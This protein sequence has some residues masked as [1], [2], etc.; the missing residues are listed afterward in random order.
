MTDNQHG[1]TNDITL[2]DHARRRMRVIGAVAIAFVI[3]GLVYSFVRPAEYESTATLVIQAPGSVGLFAPGDVDFRPDRYAA[4]Q[5]AIMRSRSVTE[6]ALTILETDF[7]D[8]PRV[9]D[10]RRAL[11]IVSEPNSNVVEVIH[12]G[13]SPDLAQAGANALVAAYLESVREQSAALIA[14]TLATI[15]GAILELNVTLDDLESRIAQ[16]SSASS[17]IVDLENRYQL[18]LTRLAQLQEA[19]IGADEA[20]LVVI[21]TEEAD[22]GAFLE[23]VRVVRS[24]EADSSLDTAL[25]AEHDSLLDRLG[26]LTGQRYGLVLD[27]QVAGRSAVVFSAAGPGEETRGGL[28]STVA[29]SLLLG[30]LF[31]LG[32]TFVM[33]A[34]RPV[35]SNPE[36]T[37]ELLRTEVLA[38]I[39]DLSPHDS[40]L[41]SLSAPDSDGGLAFRKAATTLENRVEMVRRGLDDPIGPGALPDRDRSGRFIKATRKNQV[42]GDGR[43]VVVLSPNPGQG[44]TVVTANL[45]VATARQSQRVLAI[46]ADFEH[47]HLTEM[48]TGRSF[49][50]AGLIDVVEMG[51]SLSEAVV[52]VDVGEDSRLGLLGRGTFRLPPLDFFRMPKT[53]TFLQ[54]LAEQYDLI[55]IDTP[56]VYFA[57]YAATLAKYADEVALVIPHGS[58]VEDVREFGRRLRILPANLLGVVYNRMPTSPVARH[59][60]E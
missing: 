33:P 55:F 6:Q 27:A 3:L 49:V 26:E 42:A 9:D 46:D 2:L 39:P 50:R 41:I 60:R 53:R 11:E 19:R 4:D 23:T 18:A 17:Q 40:K 56:P 20:S 36:E 31:G 44:R 25:L 48:L 47:S 30:V 21:R 54:E 59:S 14:N 28:A 10:Y 7:D 13:P 38:D 52:E 35:V 24:L 32:L 8:L 1:V 22:I 37:A 15:D 29:I 16:L 12:L 34:V 58:G 43:T 45:A 5:V 57:S 51:A